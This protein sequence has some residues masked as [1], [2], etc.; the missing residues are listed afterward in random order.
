MSRAGPRFA[1]ALAA[2]AAVHVLAVWWLLSDDVAAGGGGRGGG[3]TYTVAIALTDA[4]SQSANAATQGSPSEVRLPQAVPDVPEAPPHVEAT[5]TEPPRQRPSDRPSR[6]RPEMSP[7]SVDART[8]RD[9][10]AAE[11]PLD[12]DGPAPSD[13]LTA[14]VPPEE[15]PMETAAVAGQTAPAAPPMVPPLPGRRPP[16]PPTESLRAQ[17]EPTGAASPTPPPI[18]AHEASTTP[19]RA[20]TSEASAEE[21][22]RA[23]SE[24]DSSAAV[25]G[26]S[27][28]D[29]SDEVE[30]GVGEG[31]TLGVGPGV[32]ESYIAVLQAWLA[33]HKR[34]PAAARRG[35][36]EGTAILSFA[37]AADGTVTAYALVRSSGSGLLDRA[38]ASL[39]QSA[40]PVPPIPPA[41]GVDRLEVSVPVSY[42]LQ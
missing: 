20:P 11:P 22:A 18:S 15:L 39:I 14:P 21:L 6:T 41:L 1:I 12:A 9:S 34:Y 2:S 19:T 13:D 4:S 42:R 38:V 17:V 33:R 29:T 5:A 32:A 8:E 40:S 27:G 28:L 3:A 26:V 10:P 35:G 24:P 7:D 16:A 30:R 36:V 25:G 23:L 37:I 31:D